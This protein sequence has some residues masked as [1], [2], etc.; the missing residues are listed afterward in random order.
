M[1][2]K[3]EL[4]GPRMLEAWWIRCSTLRRTYHTFHPESGQEPFSSCEIGIFEIQS[5]GL[6]GVPQSQSGLSG[7]VWMGATRMLYLGYHGR[8]A[9]ILAEVQ[10]LVTQLCWKCQADDDR[11]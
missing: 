4:A 5:G 11:T 3:K 8:D 7:S 9:S 10:A 1:A 2:T 6:V